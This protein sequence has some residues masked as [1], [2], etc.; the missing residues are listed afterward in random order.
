MRLLAA[1]GLR[2]D[3]ELGQHFLLDENLVDLAVREAGVGP[4]DVVLEVGAGLG[5]L[6]AA[7]A[8]AAGTVHAVEIDRRLEAALRE[9]LAGDATSGS[10]GGCPPDATLE[11]LDPRRRLSLP[12]CPTRSQRRWWWRACG[13]SRAGALVRDGPARGG[14]PL[15]GAARRAAYGVPSVLL[16]LTVE[17]T[18]RR[19]VGREV[20]APRPRVDSAL[21]A[22]RRIAP[23]PTAAVR[24]L[25]RAAFGARRKTLV[26]ALAVA[27]A[28]REVTR[29]ALDAL[30]HPPASVP[31]RC[32]PASSPPWRGSCPG[33]PERV[34][35][36]EAEPE[37]GRGPRRDDGYHPLTS[38]MVVLDGPADAL[39]VRRAG[40]RR[41]RCPGI[42]G[43]ANLVWSALDALEAEAG[44]PLP[45]EVE[46]D[47]RIPTQAGLGGG[48]SDAAAALVAVDRLY[49]LGLG[50][51]RLEAVAA[52]V[53]SDVPFFVRGGAQWAEGRGERLRPAAAPEFAALLV[54]G[55]AGLSTAAVYRAFDRL[56]APGAHPPGEPPPRLPALAA[57]AR[58]DLWPAALA[59]A[60]ALGATAR[61]LAAAGAGA[62]L[63]CGS[64]S[65]LA[66]LYPDRAA[67][68]SAARGWP[69]GG[70]RAVVAPAVPDGGHPTAQGSGN[71][72]DP[73]LRIDLV[74][75]AGETCDPLRRAPT[76]SSVRGSRVP[77][78]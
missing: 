55:E 26:N 35:A 15:A 40:E 70:F 49:G 50:Q 71:S 56:P 68:E 3:T 17:P 58:N 76:R 20:F 31:R 41:V 28:D 9:A 29:A 6:T 37:A 39:E 24:G 33:A 21:V 10:L 18:F 14:R 23:G 43:P 1:H 53:G 42:E 65:C 48:S 73:G 8:R 34:R 46:I 7:L 4:G 54:K 11:A 59:L 78:Q 66:G 16:G 69:A 2:P 77:T 67:A 75:R 22:L 64:G 5:V 47:K 61:A 62:V 52:R 32:R 12:T 60:P 13:G 27:G 25:V 57:W 63:L 30:G 72:P 51:H 45:V 44:L 36:G 38:L 74:V 19:S